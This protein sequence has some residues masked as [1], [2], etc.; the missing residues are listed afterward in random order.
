MKNKFTYLQEDTLRVSC[1]DIEYLTFK[2]LAKFFKEIGFN[3]KANVS[4][5]EYTFH[6]SM[7][8]AED[9][10]INVLLDD[11]DM[12][13]RTYGIYVVSSYDL[14]P[15]ASGLAFKIPK[16][17]EIDSTGKIR[18]K[19]EEKRALFLL[20]EN[21]HARI[22]ECHIENYDDKY[23]SLCGSQVQDHIEVFLELLLSDIRKQIKLSINKKE[24]DSSYCLT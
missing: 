2:K 19:E 24:Y 22:E 12:E 1:C 14:I 20:I 5:L 8:I 13:K 23:S 17:D 11:E 6:H 3:K 16:E 10:C 18:D 21:S 9:I 7:P 4:N 15:M